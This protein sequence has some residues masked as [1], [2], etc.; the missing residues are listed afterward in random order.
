MFSQELKHGVCTGPIHIALLKHLE[1]YAKLVNKSTD[2]L[3]TP[4][5]LLSKLIAGKG[6]DT[7]APLVQEA[8]QLA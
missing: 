1:L 2:L 4:F 5:L 6:E 7:K 3:A 8:V